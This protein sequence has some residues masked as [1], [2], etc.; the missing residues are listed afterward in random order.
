RRFVTSEGGELR[1][2]EQEIELKMQTAAQSKDGMTVRDS[3]V[4]NCLGFDGLPS[5]A[6]L[7]RAA[8]EL[9][10]TVTTLAA[11]PRAEDYNG[12]VLFE[13][14][15][16]AQLIAELLGHNLAL[17]RKPVT[18]RDGSGGAAASELEGRMG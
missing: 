3:V 9:A 2:P 17:S 7:K 11:A 10:T 5:D 18:E 16:A 1:I 6:D 15:A 13:G 4:F 14:N 8:E 12:P